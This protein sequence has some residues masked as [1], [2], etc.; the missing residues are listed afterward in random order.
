MLDLSEQPLEENIEISA[1]YLTRIAKMNM[2]LEIELGV[3]GGEEDGVDNSG[4]EHDKLYTSPE[5]VLQAPTTCSARSAAS[6]SPRRSATRTAC[7]RA[8]NV[9]LKPTILRDSQKFVQEQ[10][11]T[12]AAAGEL[13][14]PR[15]LRA[16]RPRRSPRRSPTAS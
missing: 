5:D 4:V 2:T 16:R 15:R 10:R 8:G 9:K 6:P 12:G 1:K 11:K 13:R 14:L 7:T 3:T